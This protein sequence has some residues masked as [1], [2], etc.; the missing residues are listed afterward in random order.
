[1][2]TVELRGFTFVRES[3]DDKGDPCWGKT[4][5]LLVYQTRRAANADCFSS[6]RVVPCKVVIEKVPE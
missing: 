1:M 6:E 5:S 2:K 4:A 3:G